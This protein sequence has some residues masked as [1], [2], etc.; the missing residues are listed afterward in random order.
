M[1][2]CPVCYDH[3][4][5]NKCTGCSLELTAAEWIELKAD[6]YDSIISHLTDTKDP[7]RREQIRTKIALRNIKKWAKQNSELLVAIKEVYGND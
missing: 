5:D 3:I 6:T 1:S 7:R 2:K 4:R